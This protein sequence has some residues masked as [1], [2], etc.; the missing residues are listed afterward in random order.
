M[1]SPQLSPKWSGR[2]LPGQY[3]LEE[4]RAAV[5][6][7]QDRLEKYRHDPVL[8]M[9]DAGFVADPWQAEFL[10]SNDP[11][12]LLL[13]ARQVGKSS[14]VSIL[15]LHAALTKPNFTVIVIAPIETQANEL[16]RKV[17]SAYNA[18]GRPLPTQ[19]IATNGRSF[20]QEKWWS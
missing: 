18:I 17:I 6:P 4:I 12:N 14:A 2:H 7:G 1:P 10:T 3:S 5:L 20:S 9:K 15:A 8:L 13:M 16:L 11:L 19:D